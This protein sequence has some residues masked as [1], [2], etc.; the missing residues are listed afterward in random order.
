M[1]N[2]G[3]WLSTIVAR[4]CLTRLQSRRARLEE[5][6]EDDV[7]PL[8]AEDDPERDALLADALGSALLLVL[9]TLAAPE[10]LAFVLHDL[11]AVPFDE[12][13]RVLER[14]P[15]A[16]RQLARRARRRVAGA[17]GRADGSSPGSAGGPGVPGRVPARELISPGCS[18]CSTRR[19]CCVPTPLPWA[20]PAPL[21]AP[22]GARR[23]AVAQVFC[24]RAQAAR[25]ALVDG[26]P[27][28]VWAPGGDVRA[29]FDLLLHAIGS[30]SW[31]CWQTPTC[32]ASLRSSCC[33]PAGEGIWSRPPT[34]AATAPLAG[35]DDEHVALPRLIDLAVK[36]GFAPM[37]VHEASQDRWDVFESGYSARY[38]RRLAAHDHEH[39]DA[40]QVRERA[41]R[42]RT[43]YFEGYRGV[44]GL[45]YLGLV[46]V[47]SPLKPAIAAA[48]PSAR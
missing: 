25:H 1:V 41:A 47:S 32:S 9:D 19:W 37:Q 3:G 15:V 42:Q 16:A 18:P 5:P 20:R 26:L 22:Q 8:V 6:L 34:P 46:A 27:G 33:D 38:A 17:E 10:R 7:R 29:V 12:V 40:A 35:R 4:V 48:S 45:A 23:G 44:P 13:A 31:R 14:T 24:G 28:L 21:L 2:L 11:F 30:S 36:H 43:A 39:P